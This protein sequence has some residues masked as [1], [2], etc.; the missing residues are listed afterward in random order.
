M[1]KCKHMTLQALRKIVQ[2]ADEN[3]LPDTTPVV[4]AS[5][6]EGNSFHGL[7]DWELVTN[8]QDSGNGFEYEVV[9]KYDDDEEDDC[10]PVVLLWPT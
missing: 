9:Y 2:E 5:D 8:M 1:Q 10:S 7:W 4:M 6:G 3:N